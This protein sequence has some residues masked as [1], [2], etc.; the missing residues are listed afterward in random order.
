MSSS[1]TPPDYAEWLTKIDQVIAR[2]IG[3]ADVSSYSIGGMTFTNRSLD[4]VLDH[5]A[6]ILELYEEQ[7]GGSSTTLVDNSGEY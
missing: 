3:G 6:S 4:E 7:Q 5:R 1:Y 2:M